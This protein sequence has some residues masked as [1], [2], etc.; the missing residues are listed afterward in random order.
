M[1]RLIKINIKQFSW[2]LL[3]NSRPTLQFKAGICNYDIVADF[4]MLAKLLEKAIVTMLYY[5]F[6]IG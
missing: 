4:C 5:K 1:D 3:L 6:K 2:D